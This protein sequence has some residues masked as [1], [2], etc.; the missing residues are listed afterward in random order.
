MIAEK[1]RT[2]NIKL[3]PQRLFYSPEWIVLGVNNI[4]NLHC[5]MCDVGIEYSSSNFYQNLMGSH[6]VNM[7]PELIKLIFDQAANFYPSVKIGYAFTEPLIYPYLAESLL[8]AT[9]KNLYTAMTTN[10]LTLKQ[11]AGD[12]CSAGL[13][14]IFISLD[15]PEK[16]H[17]EIR[18]N[19]NSFQK[20][21]AGIEELFAHNPR[22]EV[23]VF[24]VITEWNTGH[25]K[26]FIDFFRDYPLK[27]IG[28]MHLNFITNEIAEL[29][30]NLFGAL[31]PATVSNIEQINLDKI[32]LELMLEEIIKVK[33][34][35]YPFKISFSPDI[36]DMNK[37]K[38]FYREPDK[39][40]G[41]ICNDVFRNIMI[42]S[43]GSVIPAHGRCY[44]L[45]I[46]NIYKESLK[47]IWNSSIFSKFRKEL[48][49]A[50]GLFPA[51]SRC[52]SAF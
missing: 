16:I 38:E 35:K 33:E 22:P 23:S 13:K 28:F 19:K 50:G 31:Y 6:P 5:K 1:L 2:A 32:N 47:E 25:L 30:N 36:G 11:K 3:H 26:E 37:L 46:G 40:V 10:A 20:A 14:E 9:G 18:G 34:F 39:F 49:N 43:D 15:G 4:C 44:N 51:C 52:C 48:I 7:P 45:T 17:N 21:I 27:Q 29:H 8:Y 42:K 24:S 12:L 41:K